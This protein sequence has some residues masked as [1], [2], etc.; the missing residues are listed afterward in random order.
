M[1][2]VDLAADYVRSILGYNPDTGVIAWKVAKANNIRVG[3]VAGNTNNTGYMQVCIDGRRYCT[4]RIAWLIYY[5]RWPRDQLDHIN[6]VT[7]DN[8]IVNLREASRAENMQNKASASGSTSRFVG[9][10]WDARSGMWRAQ[11]MIGGKKKHIGR[12]QKEAEAASAYA[13]VKAATH[14]FSPTARSQ[15]GGGC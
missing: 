13:A 11:I 14:K 12:F 9:V 8:R 6:G 2:H 3:D 4:H 7:T 15:A 5:G 10:H 1:K